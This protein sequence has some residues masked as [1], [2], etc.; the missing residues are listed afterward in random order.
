LF[1]SNN[2]GSASPPP[3]PVPQIPVDYEV[4]NPRREY[5]V[6]NPKRRGS[7]SSSTTASVRG[8]SI[9]RPV[10]MKHSTLPRS[11]S[12]SALDPLLYALLVPR[13]STKRPLHSWIK[14]LRAW[15]SCTATEPAAAP[16]PRPLGEAMEALSK[17]VSASHLDAAPHAPTLSTLRWP[18]SFHLT[19]P[20]L[21]L[22]AAAREK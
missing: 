18:L 8:K 12:P 17:P 9:S 20:S 19:P 13:A 11:L 4:P 15:A 16:H 6:P 7:S 5:E 2:L 10:L 21:C 3:P 14:P 1:G 22:S